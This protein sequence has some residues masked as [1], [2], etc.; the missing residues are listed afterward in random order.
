MIPPPVPRRQET[1]WT[2]EQ[3]RRFLAATEGT[4]YWLIWRL[5][6]FTGMRRAEVLALRWQDVDIDRGLLTVLRSLAWAGGKPV[7]SEGKTGSARRI[8]TLDSETVE[9]LR[10]HRSQAMQDALALAQPWTAAHLVFHNARGGPLRPDSV[11][12]TFQYTT[13]RLALPHIRLHDLRHG[14]A[15][16]ALEEGVPLKVVSEH[17]GHA[18]VA[19]TADRYMHVREDLARDGNQRVTDRLNGRAGEASAS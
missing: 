13:K 2:P 1:L 3:V 8:V 5:L 7:F 11:S 12:S 4:P 10:R 19:I 17:L 18:S 15:T 9:A 6:A 16:M 14:W